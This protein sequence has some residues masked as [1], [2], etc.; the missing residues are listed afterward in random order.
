M[1]VQLTKLAW[2]K[3]LHERDPLKLSLSTCIYSVNMFI[4]VHYL[5]SLILLWSLPYY[6]TPVLFFAMI[7]LC[8]IFM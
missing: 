8:I 1:V 3:L 7:L 2:T 5:I 4:R 6:C